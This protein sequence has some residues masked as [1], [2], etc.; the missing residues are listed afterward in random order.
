MGEL[1]PV[2][3]RR[4]EKSQLHEKNKYLKE[5]ACYPFLIYLYTYD[6]IKRN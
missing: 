6:K 5:G 1:T 4:E 3:N 2:R